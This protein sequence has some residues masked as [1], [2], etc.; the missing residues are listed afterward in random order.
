MR[1]S[2]ISLVCWESLK[3]VRGRVKGG[4]KERIEEKGE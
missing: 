4:W 2:L 1:S 3:S